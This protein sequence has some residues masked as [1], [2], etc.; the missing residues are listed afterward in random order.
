[1]EHF[2][3]TREEASVAAA[4][5]IA[6]RLAARLDVI[7]FP[8]ASKDVLTKG[9]Y[10]RFDRYVSNDYP[11]KFRKPIPNRAARPFSRWDRSGC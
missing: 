11:P 6:E 3:K 2:F 10:K 8:D 9:K 7:V 4:A 1:M 5:A